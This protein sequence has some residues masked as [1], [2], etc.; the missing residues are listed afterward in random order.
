MPNS[1]LRTPSSASNSLSSTVKLA[2]HG[3]PQPIAFGSSYSPAGSA[4]GRRPSSSSSPIRSCA[5]IAKDSGCS[6]GSSPATG[7]G[8]L[9]D[10]HIR[11]PIG[12]VRDQENGEPWQEGKRGPWSQSLE[13]QLSFKWMPR[14]GVERSCQRSA[15]VSW[16]QVIGRQSSHSQ[17][18]APTVSVL[19]RPFAFGRDQEIDQ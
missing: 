7:V 15:V 8:G 14:P 4:V 9:A 10:N 5:G 6:G 16:T 2:S 3:S 12:L 19:T 1:P 13:H 18:P 11:G 17:A